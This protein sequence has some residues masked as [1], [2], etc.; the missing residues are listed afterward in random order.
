MRNPS[1]L[2]YEG[3]AQ[4]A[5]AFTY[6]Q[7]M[8]PVRDGIRLQTVILRPANTTA[9]LPILFRRTPYGVPADANIPIAEAELKKLGVSYSPNVYEGAGH[10]FLRQ[11][12][13]AG[14]ANMKA[15][16]QAWPKTIGFLRQYTDGK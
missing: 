12:N 7:V 16:A 2:G 14:G 15:T 6:Q 4:N 1:T 11:Q 3:A 9:P 13:G 5:P 8:I 10:G